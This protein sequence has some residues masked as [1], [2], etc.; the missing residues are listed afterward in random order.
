MKR[1]NDAIK[2]LLEMGGILETETQLRLRTAVAGSAFSLS[3][4][5]KECMKDL[6]K[7][8]KVISLLPHDDIK[9]KEFQTTV[10]SLILGMNRVLD[11]DKLFEEPTK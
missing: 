11:T 3:Q 7:K 4:D 8:W 6:S 10:R 9:Y 1:A 2:Q 5:G